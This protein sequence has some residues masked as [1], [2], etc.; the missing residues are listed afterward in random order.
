M[1]VENSDFNS[2][3][4]TDLQSI[5]QITPEGELI[6]QHLRLHGTDDHQKLI[7]R[8]ELESKDLSKRPKVPHLQNSVW[9]HCSSPPLVCSSVAL[10][11]TQSA[12]NALKSFAKRTDSATFACSKDK[13]RK[14]DHQLE[15]KQAT[16][17]GI[18]RSQIEAVANEIEKSRA[19]LRQVQSIPIKDSNSAIQSTNEDIKRIDE[20]ITVQDQLKQHQAISLANNKALLTRLQENLKTYDKDYKESTA[21]LEELK[22]NLALKHVLIQQ[23][24]KQID[25]LKELKSKIASKVI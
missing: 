21:Q 12:L 8:S 1:S 9:G 25:N 17:I 5:D 7:R 10:A 11:T 18:L 14:C 13:T 19:E 15:Q 23:K 4:A 20:M 6:R 22:L 16:L 3:R 2:N 24:Q